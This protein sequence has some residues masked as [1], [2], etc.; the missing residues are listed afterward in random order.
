[1]EEETK[2]C[3]DIISKTVDGFGIGETPGTRVP[4]GIVIC[5]P[6]PQCNNSRIA[7]TDEL[8]KSVM[9]CDYLLLD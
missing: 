6:V 1:M 4:A 8:S 7:A 5:E 3:V 9:S 2:L